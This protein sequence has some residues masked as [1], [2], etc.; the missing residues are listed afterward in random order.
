MANQVKQVIG[1]IP[2]TL[3]EAIVKPVT[4]EVGKAIEQG[5]SAMASGKPSQPQITPEQ[6]E[7]KRAEEQAKMTEARRKISW[8]KKLEDEQKMIRE[9]KRQEEI[10][11]QQADKKGKEIKQYEVAQKKQQLTK[12]QQAAQR[13]QAERRIGKGVGG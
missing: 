4:D 12:G 9:R 3:G 1:A 5:V 2:Q 10:Q 6:I 13:S 8:W 11:K 7:K